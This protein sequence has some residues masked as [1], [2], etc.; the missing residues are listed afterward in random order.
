MRIALYVLNMDGRNENDR[1]TPSIKMITE[2][3]LTNHQDY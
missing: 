1:D 2:M 3:Q